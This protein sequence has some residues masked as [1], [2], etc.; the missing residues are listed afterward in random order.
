MKIITLIILIWFTSFSKCYSQIQNLSVF[1][2]AAELTV[3]GLRVNLQHGWNF[4][5]PIEKINGNILT[6]KYTFSINYDAHE[7]I[8]QRIEMVNYNINIKMNKTILIFND[9]KLMNRIKENLTYK[10]F[11]LKRTEGSESLYKDGYYTIILQEGSLDND[12]LSEGY[13]RIELLNYGKD[14]IALVQN[15]RKEEPVEEDLRILEALNS[16]S[17]RFCDSIDYNVKQLYTGEGF[18]DEDL[19]KVNEK[20]KYFVQRIKD[21]IEKYNNLSKKLAFTEGVYKRVGLKKVYSFE[22]DF[23]CIME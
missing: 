18:T 22:E 8:L 19:Q 23:Q 3:Q 11:K 14:F 15:S 6:G 17:Q 2:D 7:Q 12:N 20:Y 1:L 21:N 10:G 13:F 9:K 16:S 5:P 4:S